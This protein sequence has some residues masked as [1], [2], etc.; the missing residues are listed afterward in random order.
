VSTIPNFPEALLDKHHA[1]H[2]PSAHPGVPTRVH[3]AGSP[4]AGLE[5]LVF[6]RDFMAEFH[7]WYDQQPFADQAAV[8][9]W[10]EVPLEMRRSDLGWDAWVGDVDRITGHPSSFASAD[11]LGTFI[12][13]GVHNGFLHSAA[14]AVFNEPVLATFHSPMIT[15]FYKLH[16]LVQRWW[17]TW[18]ATRPIWRHGMPGA[19]S[20]MPVVLGT[21]PTSWYT[22]PENVQH[23][24]YVGAD[25]RI[26][27]LFFFVGPNGQWFHG[28]PGAVSDVP[29]A[30][31]TSPTS[32]YT[33]PENV[34]HIA[35]VGTD[36]RI[37]ELFFFIGGD[38]VWHHGVPGLAS[39]VLVAQGTNPTS[40]Y[41]TPEN[42]QHL[43]FIGTDQAVHELFFFIGGDGVWHHG[44]PGAVSDV[45]V[46]PGT[47]PTSWYTTPENVQHLAYAGADHSIHEL[48]FFVGPKG[49]WFHGVPGAVS[50]VP[51]APGTNPTS[52]Y[53]TPENV[54]HIAY[55][56]NDRR[57]HEL[58][59]FIR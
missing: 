41:T 37:H 18:E 32:W 54:Q 33:T 50:D 35:Y 58:F 12:E 26:H 40:W 56:G 36:Q 16:G 21:S 47:S 31:G 59:F 53:T 22:T 3:P 6:H 7:L 39:D 25:Q 1:W 29:V 8:A 11:Q 55:T 4:G 23:I 52:W 30:P 24:G 10:P 49:Q 19:A 17:D 42:V 45:P 13:L 38:G 20:D 9:P 27:E 34:Q 2:N 48:F 44:V 15:E 14:A 46:A 51:V 43:G 5:F 28:V 57:I